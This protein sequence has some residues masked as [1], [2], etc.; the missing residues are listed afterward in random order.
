MQDGKI[1]MAVLAASLFGVSMPVIAESNVSD[2]ESATRFIDDA[3]LTTRVKTALLTD[4]SVSALDIKVTTEGGVV[5]L[6]GIAS[7]TEQQ[8]ARELALAIVGVK[9]VR[10]QIAPLPSSRLSN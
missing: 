8:R 7:E 9:D 1:Y 2:K 4:S 10:T 3:A 5:Y 6:S